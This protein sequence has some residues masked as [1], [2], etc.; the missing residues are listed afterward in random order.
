MVEVVKN[1]ENKLLNRHDVVA[2]IDSNGATPSRQE[3]KSQLA[4][5]LKVDE[6]LVVIDKVDT[7]FGTRAADV[8]AKVYKDEETLKKLTL[9]HIAKRNIGPVVEEAVEETPA[10]APTA[11]VE[12]ASE[13]APAE[14]A[15]EEVVEEE[16]KEE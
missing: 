16:A 6:K 9:E 14:E 5:K 8:S 13:E 1:F 12:E 10:P 15:Q 3:I 2:R 4:K 11:P 7:S